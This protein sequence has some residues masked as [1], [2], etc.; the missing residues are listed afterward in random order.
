MAK[1]SRIFQKPD[2][3]PV[4]FHE[5]LSEAY[6]IYTPFYP[7]APENQTMVNVAFVG[8]AHP[9]TRR[10]LQK[11]KV[12]AG[13]NTTELLEIAN[14]VF[15]NR[16]RAARKEE[17]KRI[18]RRANIIAVA[19][20]DLSSQ[21]DQKGKQKYRSGRRGK[22]SLR[23]D[24]CAYCKKTGHWKNECPKW[25]SKKTGPPFPP[26]YY[27]PEPPEADLIGLAMDDAD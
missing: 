25:Q 11:L 3:G 6:Q 2:E 22:E 23:R 7:E 13:K 27:E 18:Q 19:F 17:E 12:F 14:K 4:A 21:T 8:Q 1:I 15:I 26:S 20:R 16:W 24:Q 9:D 5:R 10:K